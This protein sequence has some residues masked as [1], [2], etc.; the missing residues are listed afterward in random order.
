MSK[1]VW[2]ANAR[3]IR[4][5]RQE[6]GGNDAE[7]L[8]R[9]FLDDTIIGTDGL[10][11]RVKALLES[12]EQHWFTDVRSWMDL[13]G[14]QECKGF[15]D[16][17]FRPEFQDPWFNSCDQAGHFLTAIGLSL[18]PQQ[19]RRAKFWVRMR[20]WLGA[21]KDM[22]DEEVALRLIIGHEKYPDPY[23]PDPFVLPKVRAQFAAATAEDTAAF[24]AA[25][26]C[27]GPDLQLDLGCMDEYLAPIHVG[28][29]RGNSLQDLRLSCAGYCFVQL[30][31]SGRLKT[32]QE[33]GE[34]VRR[35]LEE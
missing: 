9:F 10:T 31:R 11:G 26:A 23:K 34:W 25:I 17:G 33:A 29:G 21:P 3:R 2:V 14:L 16:N 1:P 27:L 7:A 6:A 15:S 22:D 35:N 28:S 32:R 30:L 18:Y 4:E 8:A 20:D 5:I 13:P 19:L 12:T 24:R